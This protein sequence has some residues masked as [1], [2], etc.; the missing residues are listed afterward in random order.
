MKPPV[1]V[2][3]ARKILGK[4]ANDMADVEIADVVS[5]LTLLAKDTLEEQRI[6]MLRKRDAKRLAELIYKMYKEEK[7]TK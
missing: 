1:S 3:E 4:D 5:T 6:K 7:F 2:E